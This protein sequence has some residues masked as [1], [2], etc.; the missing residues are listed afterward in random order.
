MSIPA[1]QPG[2]GAQPDDS[3]SDDQQLH[4]AQPDQDEFSEQASDQA[5]DQDSEPPLSAPGGPD[6]SVD[7]PGG[8]AG[9]DDEATTGDDEDTLPAGTHG[10]ARRPPADS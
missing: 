4:G 3:P 8:A 6:G 2:T 1:Q 9:Q 5:S 7:R 10:T